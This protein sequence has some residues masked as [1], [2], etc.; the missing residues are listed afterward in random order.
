MNPFRAARILAATWLVALAT[1]APSLACAT[2]DEP[3]LR[4]LTE[5]NPP[6]ST[7]AY[8]KPSGIDTQVVEA[9]LA[10]A[11]IPYTIEV[12]PWARA[13]QRTL[14][15]P[16]TLLYSTART[17]E[18]EA[19]FYWIGPIVVNRVALYRLKSR[20][21]IAVRSLEDARRYR[22]GVVLQ[23]FRGDYLRKK[24]FVDAPE[25]GLTTVPRNEQLLPMLLADHIDLFP[26]SLSTCASGALDCSR[27][28]PVLMLEG[29]DT[30]LFMVFAHGTNEALVE[31]VR[32]GFTT[33]RKNGTLEK[34]VAPLGAARK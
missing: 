5:D 29:L 34:I 33:I 7:E 4:V 2:G 32:A 31:K 1:V 13:Y 25:H 15:E 27:I 9:T 17:P 21:D 18:R 10:A 26:M 24:G 23:D 19:S 3:V 30:Q 6:Y 8:G 16:G 14:E 28:E 22:V 20:S 11:K 12:E